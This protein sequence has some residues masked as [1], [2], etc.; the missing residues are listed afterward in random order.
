MII[1]SVILVIFIIS[2][3]G[4]LFMMFRK[5]PKLNTLP[6]N[7]TTGIKKHHF[8]LETEEK[9]KNIFIAFEKQIWLHKLLSWLKVFIL[10]I[11]T[12]VD[13]LLHKIRQKNKTK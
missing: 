11:E 6:R 12:R 2:F 1:E 5:I 4:L 13:H 8:I 9:I 3:G 7:G 10:K